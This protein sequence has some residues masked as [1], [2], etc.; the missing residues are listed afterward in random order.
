MCLGWRLWDPQPPSAS[1]AAPQSCRLN[2]K[3][4]WLLGQA[5][6]SPL[7]SPSSRLFNPLPLQ[8]QPISLPT[9]LSFSSWLWALAVFQRWN[10]IW[11]DC[12][13][14][15]CL[16]G[17]RRWFVMWTWENNFCSYV[18]QLMQS[19]Q[20]VQGTENF[21]CTYLPAALSIQYDFVR[22]VCCWASISFLCQFP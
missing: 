4:S 20:C 12:L 5:A 3:Q 22:V 8:L 13:N 10:C 6:P 18:G 9:S 16:W 17:K 11:L 7:P 21:S 2:Q 15:L 1:C 19:G 14:N